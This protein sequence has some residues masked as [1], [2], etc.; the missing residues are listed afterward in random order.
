[1][2]SMQGE[3]SKQLWD[4]AAEPLLP[5]GHSIGTP[6]ILFTKIEDDVI[7]SELNKLPR[8]PEGTPAQTPSAVRP[9]GGM[10]D[11]RP[12]IS[13]DDFKKIDLRVAKIIAAEPVPK[14]EKLLK[15]QVEVGTEKRQILAGIAKHYTPE[16][17]VGKSVV[18]V[19]N[20][21]PAKLMG[22]ESQ[23][24]LLAASDNDGKLVFITPSADIGSGSAV[25]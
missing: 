21:Q 19:F 15:L 17:L 10:P 6:E 4:S 23:G 8:T 7:A 16:D 13:I 2:L 9:S 25:K 3:A 24:M 1:M 12:N 20:L 11:A 22:H 18:V 14:S 5:E